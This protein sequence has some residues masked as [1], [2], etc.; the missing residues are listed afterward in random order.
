[1]TTT[2]I[3]S[4]FFLFA[5]VL[6]SQAS[7]ANLAHASSGGDPP[8]DCT[9]SL[10]VI[11]TND[12]GSGSLRQAVLNACPN[13]IIR[14]ADNLP[15][16]LATEIVIE[17]NL[18][19]DASDVSDELAGTEAALLQISGG[20]G[21]RIFRVVEGASLALRRLRLSNGVLD[22]AELGGAIRNDGTLSASECRFDGNRS[23]PAN[24]LGG[25]AIFNAV[26]AT[27]LVEQ[28]TFDANISQRGAAIFNSGDAELYNS[29]FS[30]NVAENGSTISEGAIQNRGTLLADHITVTNNTG[31]LTNSFGGLFAF[32]AD[33][34]LLNSVIAGNVGKDC[35]ISGGTSTSVGLLSQTGN[36]PR[37]FNSDPLLGPLADN[38]GVTPTHMPSDSSPA[39]GVGDAT[40]C[41]DFDQRG[42]ARTQPGT[43]DLG[44]IER[45][46]IFANGFE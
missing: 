2:K 4:V 11:N 15:I 38:G 39:L 3:A 14:F 24:N 41:L 43:C 34:T 45:N 6:E 8:Q 42:A 19:I 37:D 35:E 1:M 17:R 5:C 46:A 40:L 10:R 26:G 44:A 27:L 30:G 36:C 16:Q 23:G 20:P 22:G 9:T 31:Q 21:N 12:S 29:T 33:T 28:S 18:T 32:S 7:A 13:G 25:G